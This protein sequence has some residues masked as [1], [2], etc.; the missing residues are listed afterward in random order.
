M[1]AS[2]RPR[3][4]RGSPPHDRAGALLVERLDGPLEPDE[5]TW[6]ADHLA[7]C[8][9]CWALSEAFEADRAELQSLRRQP[10]DPPRDLW[11]RTAAA[12]EQEARSGSR[13]APRRRPSPAPVGAAAG[14]LVVAVVIGASMLSG[15]QMITPPPL[16]SASLEVAVISPTP[17]DAS[18][19]PT[20]VVATP[21]ATPGATPLAIPSGDV[22]YIALDDEGNKVFLVLGVYEV[23][24]ENGAEC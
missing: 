9:A 23:C 14:L 12:L 17:V 22:G 7:G 6:L 20:T 11:A 10:V 18:V 24:A 15:R 19:E 2:W 16:P 3:P 13:R 1:T 21:E 5:A 4:D 8:R